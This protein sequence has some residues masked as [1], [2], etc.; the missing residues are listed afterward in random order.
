MT[1]EQTEAVGW[2]ADEVLAHPHFN[3]IVSE[4]EKAAI[5]NILNSIPPA[6]SEREEIYFTY[7]GAKQFLDFMRTC[8]K[9]KNDLLL[10]RAIQSQIDEEGL[11]MAADALE[12]E[13][14]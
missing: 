14:D 10:Q 6:T 1:E 4:F 3:T 2:Y 7:N 11:D 9:G 5:Y 8:V 13:I 12:D